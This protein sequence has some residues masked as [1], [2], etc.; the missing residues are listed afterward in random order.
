MGCILEV[1]DVF[2]ENKL[3]YV[4]GKVVNVGGVVI[5]GLEMS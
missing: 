5:L 2:I 4:L 1:I 3:M